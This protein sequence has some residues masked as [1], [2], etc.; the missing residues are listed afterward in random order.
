[1]PV[2][3]RPTN[4]SATGGAG[5]PVSVGGAAPAGRLASVTGRTC[6][7]PACEDAADSTLTWVYAD[8]TAVLGP[9]SPRP[10][11]HSYDLCSRHATGLS[12][13]RGWSVIRYAAVDD[14]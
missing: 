11:P 3:A 6:S 13:P 4:G 12:A 9:L 14:R 7:R 1:M 10:E 2:V 5:H 8:R